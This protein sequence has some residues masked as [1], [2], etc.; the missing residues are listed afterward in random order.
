MV[1]PTINSE[2]HM[3]AISLQTV[4]DNTATTFQLCAAVADPSVSSE[5]RI[6][7]VVKAVHIELWYLSSASQ[8][9]FHISTVEKLVSGQTDPSSAQMSALHD[10]PNKKNIFQTSQGLIGDANSNPIP[11]FREWIKIP[12]GKQRMGLGDKLILTVAARGEANNDIEV[13]GMTIYKEYF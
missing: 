9:T 1:R 10:Y 12:K 5:V 4:S 3:R 11:V 2:K 6:G 7:A 8:P 13:C